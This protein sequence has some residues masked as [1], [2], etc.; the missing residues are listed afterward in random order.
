MQAVW[1]SLLTLSGTYS[2]LVD[3][4]VFA[5]LLFYVLTIA[6]VF[7]LRITRPELERPYKAF[8]YPWIPALYIVLTAVIMIALLAYKPTYTWPGLLIVLAGV[9]VYHFS[10]R[11]VV[12]E[13]K[14]L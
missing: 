13:V 4:V 3:Y 14:P 1:A 6:A 2:D 8:G 10:R 5:V 11:R 9:P 7:R 12:A